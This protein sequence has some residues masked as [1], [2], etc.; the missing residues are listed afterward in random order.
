MNEA[1][2]VT[3]RGSDEKETNLSRIYAEHYSIKRKNPKKKFGGRTPP[4]LK[5][6]R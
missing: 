2:L 3:N 4:N 1:G 6:T 5:G